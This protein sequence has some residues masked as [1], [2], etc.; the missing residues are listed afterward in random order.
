MNNKLFTKSIKKEKYKNE[1]L[2]SPNEFLTVFTVWTVRL[3]LRN[4][5]VRE[6]QQN[7]KI[8]NWDRYL[9][10]VETDYQANKYK[11]WLTFMVEFT[12]SIFHTGKMQ[13]ANLLDWLQ[14]LQV[15]RSFALCDD[16]FFTSSRW[17]EILLQ[18]WCWCFAEC[19]NYDPGI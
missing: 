5:R 18:S 9:G 10:Y 14:S 19:F 6:N 2:W 3:H 4:D 12:W 11:N 17:M 13:R 1:N 8:N 15:N 7:Y 16:D